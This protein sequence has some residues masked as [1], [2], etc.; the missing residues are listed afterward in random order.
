MATVKNQWIAGNIGTITPDCLES[1]LAK[2]ASNVT[3][4]ETAG[5]S[6]AWLTYLLA[7]PVP[8]GFTGFPSTT[9][10]YCSVAGSALPPTLVNSNS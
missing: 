3:I 10:S 1:L 5:V 8:A 7:Q 6:A 9:P 4:A 2:S